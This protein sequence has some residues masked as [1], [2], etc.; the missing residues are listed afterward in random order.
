MNKLALNIWLL[1]NQPPVEDQVNRAHSADRDPSLYAEH[2]SCPQ[3]IFFS[4]EY[5]CE[6]WPMSFWVQGLQVKFQPDDSSWKP[7]LC[8]TMDQ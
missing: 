5:L 1:L 7:C 4:P 2:A 6:L 8:F 3:P